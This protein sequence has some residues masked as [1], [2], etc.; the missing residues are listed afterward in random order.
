[1]Y[2]INKSIIP[3]IYTPSIYNYITYPIRILA[4]TN[5][6]HADKKYACI[7][8]RCIGKEGGGR[9]RRRGE[10]GSRTKQ[11]RQ[12]EMHISLTRGGVVLLGCT[13][14]EFQASK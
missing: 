4:N 11:R 2:C 7:R 14:E 10:W 5:A 12:S 1:M 9:G 3:I 6:V 13:V 8:P